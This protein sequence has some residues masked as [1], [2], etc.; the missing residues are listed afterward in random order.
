MAGG[1]EEGVAGGEEEGVAG[2][3][4]RADTER[5]K[6][7]GDEQALRMGGGEP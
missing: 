7:R 5:E 3:E 2:D 6:E 4:A 1:G